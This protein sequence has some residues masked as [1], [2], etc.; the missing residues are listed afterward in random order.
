MRKEIDRCEHSLTFTETKKLSV[1]ACAER[2]FCG[3]F[4]PC[5]V[6]PFRWLTLWYGMCMANEGGVSARNYAEAEASSYVIISP[7]QEKNPF[8][9]YRGGP[10][11]G[12]SSHIRSLTIS[13]TFPWDGGNFLPRITC[14]K[15]DAGRIQGELRK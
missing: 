8:P 13:L 6:G 1:S 5:I 14:H 3:C 11:D 12:R 7:R 9:K 4:L 15:G 10:D 2:L